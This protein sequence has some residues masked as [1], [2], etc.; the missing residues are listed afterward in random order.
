[1]SGVIT[2]VSPLL[3]LGVVNRPYSIRVSFRIRATVVQYGNPKE[4]ALLQ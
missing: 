1:M 3:P 2:F 4:I